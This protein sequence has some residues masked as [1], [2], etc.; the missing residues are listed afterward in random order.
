MGINWKKGLGS[1]RAS[2][3]G[4]GFLGICKYCG[5]VGHNT[6][7]C[8]RKLGQC[9]TCG[10]TGRIAAI[11]PRAK[12]DSTKKPLHAVDPN[13]AASGYQVTPADDKR[14]QWCNISSLGLGGCVEL[15]YRGNC[16]LSQLTIETV[17]RDR[18][19]SA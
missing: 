5:M 11:C 19:Q 6:M 4:Q 9:Y 8:R 14:G 16:S 15:D 18:E 12:G 13:D 10:D 1:S 2:S 3:G 17:E 7:A